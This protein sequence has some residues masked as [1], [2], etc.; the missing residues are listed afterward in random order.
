MFI[1]AEDPALVTALQ[2]AWA[3]PDHESETIMRTLEGSLGHRR[4]QERTG[5]QMAIL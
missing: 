4:P 2:T 3:N 1:L 5:W